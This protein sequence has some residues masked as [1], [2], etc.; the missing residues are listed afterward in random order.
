[1]KPLISEVT[2]EVRYVVKV[3]GAEVSP[4]Y[5]TQQAADAALQLLSEAHQSIAEIIAV[6]KTGQ[7]LL[8][9]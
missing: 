5:T 6:T 3:N 4:R 8:L 9:E 1:M 2:D 7:Q